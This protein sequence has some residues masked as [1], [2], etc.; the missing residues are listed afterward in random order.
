[1][2]LKDAEAE[3]DIIYQAIFSP[4]GIIE[5]SNNPHIEVY[6][7][8]YYLHLEISEEE[9]L[10]S[11]ECL[12]LLSNIEL[13]QNTSMPNIPFYHYYYY[14]IN[15]FINN[16]INQQLIQKLEQFIINP[17]FINL[18]VREN[19]NLEQR[20]YLN[21]NIVNYYY[22]PNGISVV[23]QMHT[24]LF[25]TIHNQCMTIINEH[26]AGQSGGHREGSG[27]RRRRGRN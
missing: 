16:D 5:A 20:E 23:P 27:R 21:G 26:N 10:T 1:M 11:Q 17:Y 3:E 12:T 22:L 18:I 7:T 14:N 25:I 8:I 9:K 4:F 2:S 19:E 24:G 6:L 15:P 13:N